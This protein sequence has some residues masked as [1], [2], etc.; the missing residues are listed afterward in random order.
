MKKTTIF[1]ISRSLS[2]HLNYNFLCRKCCKPRSH[3]RRVTLQKFQK[4]HKLETFDQHFFKRKFGNSFPR[5]L[6][7][8]PNLKATYSL[9]NDGICNTVSSSQAKCRN[10]RILENNIA[11]FANTKVSKICKFFHFSIWFRNVYALT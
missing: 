8:F 11:P 5:T 4:Q 3:P 6:K 1:A 9:V 10:V 7:F 2:N